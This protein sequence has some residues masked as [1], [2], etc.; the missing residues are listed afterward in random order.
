[1]N[2]TTATAI[3]ILRN[4]MLAACLWIYDGSAENYIF[5]TSLP[6]NLLLTHYKYILRQTYLLYNFTGFNNIIPRL[7]LVPCI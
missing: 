6:F 3:E 7:D 5:I 4:C 1:M 2:T